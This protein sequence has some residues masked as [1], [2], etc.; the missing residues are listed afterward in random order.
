M[1]ARQD[2]KPTRAIAAARRRNVVGVSGRYLKQ[3]EPD[4]FA[5]VIGK[6]EAAPARRPAEMNTKAVQARRL[7]RRLSAAMIA[8]L[9]AAYQAG[10][11][12]PELCK[13]YGLSKGGVLK[14]LGEAG[15]AMRKQ[16]MTD[17][18]TEL[19]VRLYGEGRSLAAIGDQLGKAKS[20]VREALIARGA[21]M[22]PS[23]RR[24]HEK[25]QN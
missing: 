15:V 5:Q 9:V 3:W 16:P 23:T 24:K 19:A 17:E 1:R 22:R 13:R 20:S 12:T 8:E 18:Q 7:D 21:A 10:T 4:R 14:L 25:A 11:S 6:I 2:T